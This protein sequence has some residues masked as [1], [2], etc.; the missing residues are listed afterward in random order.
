MDFILPGQSILIFQKHSR[1]GQWTAFEAISCECTIVIL[2]SDE[3]GTNTWPKY[4]W[5]RLRAK[6]SL[7]GNKWKLRF[8]NECQWLTW[9]YNCSFWTHIIKF[10]SRDQPISCWNHRQRQNLNL[11]LFFHGFQDFGQHMNQFNK[12]QRVS[13]VESNQILDLF[14]IS[15]ISLAW[16]PTELYFCSEVKPSHIWG[17]CWVSLSRLKMKFLNRLPTGSSTGSIFTRS[18]TRNLGSDSHIPFR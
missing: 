15:S 16:K 9:M 12:I 18:L 1:C 3:T 4:A 5:N 6:S 10:Q 14:T 13:C 17:L 11:S 2:T 8:K 7:E